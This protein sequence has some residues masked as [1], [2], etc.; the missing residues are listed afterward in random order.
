MLFNEEMPKMTDEERADAARAFPGMFFDEYGHNKWNE[1]TVARCVFPPELKECPKVVRSNKEVAI[2]ALNP[3][4]GYVLHR[5]GA[6]TE[7]TNLEKLVF[8]K[9]HSE[10]DFDGAD[11][12]LLAI[13]KQAEKRSWESDEVYK[14]RVKALKE[15]LTWIEPPKEKK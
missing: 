9:E 7:P 14:T 4:R 10:L 11:W 5:D 2:I 15:E 12:A 13:G 3:K 8:S 1:P 6:K